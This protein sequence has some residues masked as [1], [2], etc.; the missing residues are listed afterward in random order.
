LPTSSEANTIIRRAMY[1]GSSPPEIMT[2]SQYTA[3]SASDPR[4]LLMKAEM[5]S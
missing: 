4:M 5:T 2:A 3:A 1:L